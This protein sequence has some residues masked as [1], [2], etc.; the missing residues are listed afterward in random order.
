MWVPN[1]FPCHGCFWLVMQKS[2][3]P[4]RTSSLAGLEPVSAWLPDEFVQWAFKHP[5]LPVCC[6]GSAGDLSQF[7]YHL[8]LS[9]QGLERS[10]YLDALFQG[11]CLSTCAL[12]CS[13]GFL[14]WVCEW[15][16]GIWTLVAL[17]FSHF[18]FLWLPVLQ[19]NWMLWLDP[20]DET[21]MSYQWCVD[22]FVTTH[23]CYSNDALPFGGSSMDNKLY[24]CFHGCFIIF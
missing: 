9:P 2:A 15:N 22:A 10:L 14:Q 21:W 17:Y 6:W 19:C 12:L 4:V 11:S 23:R 18:L 20:I 5:A 13:K 24:Q 3:L 16:E 8:Q 1:L 7:P